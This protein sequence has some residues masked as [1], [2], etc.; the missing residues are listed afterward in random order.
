MN[1]N[2]SYF[3]LTKME[4]KAFEKS[5]AKVFADDVFPKRQKQV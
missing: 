3:G 4:M 1:L 5:W 2:D